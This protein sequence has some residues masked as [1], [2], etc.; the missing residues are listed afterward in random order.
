MKAYVLKSSGKPSK[1]KLSDVPDPFPGK[2][3]VLV[4]MKYIGIN[5]AEIMSRKGLYGWAPKRP[6]ILGME[7]SGLIEAVGVGVDQSRIGQEVMVGTQ[8]GCYAEKIAVPAQRAIPCIP[9][10]SL[11]ESAAFL[12]NYMTAWMALIELAKIN[13][14]E[15]VL[16]TAAA[17]G[18]GT[19]A[20][21]LASKH[22]CKVFG[23]A[24]S[25]EKISYIKTLGAD[26]GFNY[27]DDDC[28][29]KLGKESQGID[30]VLEMVGGNVYKKSFNL[31]DPLGRLIVIGFAS[32]DFKWWNPVTWWRTLHD[33]P[34]MKIMSL[35][36][37]SAAIMASHLGYLL[38]NPDLMLTIYNRMKDFVIENNIKPE[39][40]KVF[41]F[42][43]A[44]EAHDFI[45]SR[46]S[47][48]KILLEI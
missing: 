15:K 24:G 17:G 40:G 47:K 27:R 48:G 20:I 11:E 25:K 36:E 2:G 44:S 42:D 30:V 32:L 28:F 31:L 23:L 1:L 45:E 41:T 13:K 38:N 18:V 46:Q 7:G 8:F 14:N 4:Q 9:S 5:Y 29:E 33:I 22:G 19:A 39:I 16:I 43:K 12:V 35:A 34:R 10:Y 21:Q 37:K 3:E 6:Y 26:A